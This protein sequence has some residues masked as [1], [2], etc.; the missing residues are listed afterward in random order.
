MGSLAP[1]FIQLIP[2]KEY[3]LFPFG[4]AGHPNVLRRFAII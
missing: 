4:F 3:M 1:F 2:Q